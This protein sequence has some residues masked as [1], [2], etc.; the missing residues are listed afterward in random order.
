MWE[1][2]YDF[3]NFL[4]KKIQRYPFDLHHTI[5]MD[6]DL[7]NFGREVGFVPE[8]GIIKFKGVTFVLG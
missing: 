5:E 6:L 1:K 4:D 2:L 8:N 3:M 7:Y